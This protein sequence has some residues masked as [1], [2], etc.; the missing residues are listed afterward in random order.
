MHQHIFKTDWTVFLWPLCTSSQLFECWKTCK[1]R[2]PVNGVR[3][4][5][6]RPVLVGRGILVT[7]GLCCWII[8]RTVQHWDSSNEKP[9]WCLWKWIW[10]KKQSEML[11]TEQ[12]FIFRVKLHYLT[13]HIKLRLL[14]SL[15]MSQ[16]MQFHPENEKPFL[17]THFSLI[18]VPYLLPQLC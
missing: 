13:P 17:W 8:F 14:F 1:L 10:I 2:R 6:C 16:I 3:K 11:L 15:L 18:F 12:L 5:E 4:K 7:G 9:C